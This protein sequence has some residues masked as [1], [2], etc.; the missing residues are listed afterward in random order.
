MA[1]PEITEFEPL[2]PRVAAAV[3]PA[4]PAPTVTVYE[5][6]GDKVAVEVK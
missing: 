5:V 6:D 2:D 3:E 1:I 4:P